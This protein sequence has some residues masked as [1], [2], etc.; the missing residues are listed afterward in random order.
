MA[1]S[2]VPKTHKILNKNALWVAL[3]AQSLPFRSSQSRREDR[4]RTIHSQGDIE[5]AMTE[6]RGG[7]KEAQLLPQPGADHRQLPGRGENQS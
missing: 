3:K 2:P 4:T 1:V 6:S 5:S 7:E